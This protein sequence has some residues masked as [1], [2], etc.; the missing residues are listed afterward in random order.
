VHFLRRR[1]RPLAIS[2]LSPRCS[3]TASGPRACPSSV[4]FT[5]FL[6]KRPPRILLSRIFAGVIN[7]SFG[8]YTPVREFPLHSRPSRVP[9]AF[10]FRLARVF[11]AV[12]RKRLPRRQ[13]IRCNHAGGVIV[14]SITVTYRLYGFSAKTYQCSR[15][16]GYRRAAQSASRLR[17]HLPPE[18]SSRCV[19]FA[20]IPRTLSR[21]YSAYFAYTNCTNTRSFCL[22]YIYI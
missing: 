17:F 16:F 5:S 6:A 11:L 3:F 22:K 10:P 8:G 20:D 4:D 13:F 9:L 2:R 18:D 21:S 12:G 14:H 7:I 19:S 1:G 15:S